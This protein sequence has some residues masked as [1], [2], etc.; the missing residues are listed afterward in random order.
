MDMIDN[1]DLLVKAFFEEHTHEIADHGFSKRVMRHLPDRSR[2]LN[3]I[4][5][6]VC[7]V[8]GIVFFV[9]VRGW[10]VMADALSVCVRT[11]P[12]QDVFQL[13]PLTIVLSVLILTTVCV[14]QLASRELHL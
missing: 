6:I 9:A 14:W 13:S 4:W 12:A 2:R 1:D 3:R 7:C 11:V 10:H 5:T 8:L